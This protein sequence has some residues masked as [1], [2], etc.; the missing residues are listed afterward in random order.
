MPFLK[1]LFIDPF[2]LS[3]TNKAVLF[4][5]LFLFFIILPTSLL[6]LNN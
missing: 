6:L 2:F 1:Y 3:R 4:L 5:F